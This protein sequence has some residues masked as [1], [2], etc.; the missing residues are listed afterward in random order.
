MSKFVKL[1][2]KCY[3]IQFLINV[4]KQYNYSTTNN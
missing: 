2:Q 4:S 1:Y 3:I